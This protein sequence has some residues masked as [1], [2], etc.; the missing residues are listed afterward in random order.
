MSVLSTPLVADAIARLMNRAK[1]RLKPELLFEEIPGDSAAV[2]VPTRHGDVAAMLYRPATGAAAGLYVNLHGG[3]YVV[4]S[5]EQ[6]DPW[7]RYLAANADVFV[8]NIDYD[9]A[10]GVRFPVPVEEAYDVLA[11]AAQPG[12][13]WDGGRLAIGGQSAGGGIAAGAARLAHEL[14]A[15]NLALQVLHYPP[16]D[17][18]TSAKD[19]P[20]PQKNV[21]ITPVMGEIFDTAYV[22]DVAQRRDRLVSPAWED[23]LGGLEGIAPAMVVTCGIDRLRAEGVRY[24]DALE[25][26]GALREHLDLAGLDHGYN[27]LTTRKAA[28][29]GYAPIAA[30][31][32]EALT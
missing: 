19:K 30:R 3:G 9:V 21:V 31:V 1:P 5:P 25:A 26:V 8:L 32:R 11:W 13:E 16:L 22:P 18:A 10:P 27:I 17:L 7:C 4:R 20:A 14:G 12:H 24:A 23:N 6:D 28:E 29:R 2:T 15:P